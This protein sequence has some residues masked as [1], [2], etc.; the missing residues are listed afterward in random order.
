[1]TS[2]EAVNRSFSE[3][4]QLNHAIL[5]NKYWYL[6][7]DNKGHENYQPVGRARKEF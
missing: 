4:L 3:R 5:E 6:P 1:M 2:L 7:T